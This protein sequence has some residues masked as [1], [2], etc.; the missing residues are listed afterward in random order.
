MIRNRASN[1]TLLSLER[2]VFQERNSNHPEYYTPPVC[3]GS[4]GFIQILL[5]RKRLQNEARDL[6]L[7]IQ[8]LSSSPHISYRAK[9]AQ[10]FNPNSAML[11]I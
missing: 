4:K 9:N 5:L 3:L 6:H 2:E 10:V 7:V 11:K 8:L 1:E